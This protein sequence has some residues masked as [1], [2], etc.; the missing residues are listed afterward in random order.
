MW[1]MILDHL[2]LVVTGNTQLVWI[3]QTFLVFICH[4]CFLPGWKGSWRNTK[5]DS[6]LGSG[7]TKVL[8]VTY[9]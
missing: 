3:G 6:G 7:R 4:F 8:K 1:L 2:S 5:F 9:T